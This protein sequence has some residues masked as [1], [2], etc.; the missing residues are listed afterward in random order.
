MRLGHII[1][2]QNSASSFIVNFAEGFIAFL[3]GCVPESDFNVL[4]ANLDNFGEKLD[5]YCSLLRLIELIFDVASGNIG[6]AGSCG[7][8][9]DDFEHLVVILHLQ[10]YYKSIDV[11]YQKCKMNIVQ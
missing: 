2:Y 4:V 7:S 10:S 3:T 9:D 6:L 1:D 5:S 8:D 11:H